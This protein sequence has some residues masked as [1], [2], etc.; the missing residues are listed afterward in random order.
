MFQGLWI[1]D[2]VRDDKK[3]SMNKFLNYIQDCKDVLVITS[4]PLDLD[5]L[6]SGLLVTKYLQFLG[7]KVTIIHPEK[8]KD[9]DLEFFSVL[10]Y[11]K[12]IKAVDSREIL[13]KKSFDLLIFVDGM[14]LSQ[15]MDPS[16]EDKNP[17]DLSKFP[18]RVHIDHH[19]ANEEGLGTLTY[20]Y[21]EYSS[22]TEV[23]LK[24][25][26]PKEALTPEMATLG[27][28][29]IVGDT[30]NFMW[31][32]I[33]QTFEITATLLEKGADIQPI[34]NTLYFNKS[35]SYLE[36]VKLAIEYTQFDKAS[37]TSFLLLSQQFLGKHHF[38]E[39]R[40][41]E[42][43]LAYQN[44]IAHAMPEYPR[45]IIVHEKEPNVIYLSGRG[46]TSGNKIHFVPLFKSIGASSGG[47][48]NAAGAKVEG[49]FNLVVNQ[50]K[51][52]IKGS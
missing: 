19:S 16:S 44:F 31:N 23:V 45:G 24:H 49:K 39:A 8:F 37:Q 36:S 43:K 4:R 27:Y 35:K 15:F 40:L 13:K 41:S 50:L 33:P 28:A 29:G 21:P 30:G 17:I 42:I 5:S 51:R 48:F 12:E 46:H 10:P 32:F 26:I 18:K 20:Y 6:G 25:L 14:N 38:S 1:P 9:N 2:Q 52:A 47:H 22:A 34:L 7:K 11:F 3:E